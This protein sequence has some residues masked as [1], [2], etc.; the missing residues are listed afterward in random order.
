MGTGGG[1]RAPHAVDAE[2]VVD[3]VGVLEE[4]L[5]E[6]RAAPRLQLGGDCVEPVAH[7]AAAAAPH[8][9]AAVRIV[10]AQESDKCVDNHLPQTDAHVQ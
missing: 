10:R 6:R 7:R 3:E 5:L 4:Q 1:Q 2:A 9:R 8:L